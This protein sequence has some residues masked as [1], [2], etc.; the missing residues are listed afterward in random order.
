MSGPHQWMGVFA[1]Q[2]IQEKSRPGGRLQ[3]RETNSH[4]TYQMASGGSGMAFPVPRTCWSKSM[5]EPVMRPLS[6]DDR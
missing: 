6:A 5:I 3:V 2:D 1:E 4:A